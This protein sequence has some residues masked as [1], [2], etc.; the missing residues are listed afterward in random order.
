MCGNGSYRL[1]NVNPG[2]NIGM[3]SLDVGRLYGKVTSIRTNTVSVSCLHRYNY[4]LFVFLLASIASDKLIGV[5]MKCHRPSSFRRV[6]FIISAP[7]T[8][9]TFP[10]LF[11]VM[12][13]DAGHGALVFF[14][15]LPM[16]LY[17]RSLG[18]KKSDNEVT[19]PS[20]PTL[21]IKVGGGA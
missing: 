10:F 9:I 14:F 1:G 8:I 11:S 21:R 4:F 6:P 13:G 3:R 20:S 5:Q 7:Y 12:F 16:C 18:K 17:E 19:R 2:R 15:A